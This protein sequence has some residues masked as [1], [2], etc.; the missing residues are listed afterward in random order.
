MMVGE[1]FFV[2]HRHHH[3]QHLLLGHAANFP[4][5][6]KVFKSRT[7]KALSCEVPKNEVTFGHRRVLSQVPG[8]RIRK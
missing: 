2:P 1:D 7:G 8:L 3:Q 5:T 6:V 4:R